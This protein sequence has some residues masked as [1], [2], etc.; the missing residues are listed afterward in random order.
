[1]KTTKPVSTVCTLGSQIC[2]AED[3]HLYPVVPKMITFGSKAKSEIEG[4]YGW[5]SCKKRLGPGL[6]LYLNAG[7]LCKLLQNS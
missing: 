2:Q 7:C 3:A 6:G 5:F 4:V 1:M